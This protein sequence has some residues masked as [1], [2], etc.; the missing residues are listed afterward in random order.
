M[1][2]EHR[3]YTLPHGT[4]DEY[5]DRYERAAL[6]LLTQHLGVLVGF[7]S[8]EIGPLNQVVHIWAFTSL[9][10]RELRRARLDAD[11]AWVEFKRSNRGSFVA[12]EVKIMN[13]AS[14]SPGSVSLPCSPSKQ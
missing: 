3:T 2:V 12:Q 5:L 1:I 7:Y 8:S 10:D 14:F 13:V 6:P 9:A 4:M 11:P